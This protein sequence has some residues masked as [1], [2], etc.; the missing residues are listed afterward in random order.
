MRSAVYVVL[1]LSTVGVSVVTPL[2]LFRGTL[3]VTWWDY[4]FPFLGI[5]LWFLLRAF[6]IGGR[7]S[8]TNLIIELFSILMV[9]ITVPWLR[10]LM[11][12]ARSRFVSYLSSFLTLFPMVA[13]IFVR[14][15]MPLLPE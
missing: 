10:F 8:R 3:R 6:H 11:T 15:A 1:V 5:P 14:L 2:I 12:F 13:A 7:I 4:I 9:S